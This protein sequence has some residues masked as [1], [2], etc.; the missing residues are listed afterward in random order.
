M[1][2]KNTTGVMSYLDKTAWY[3]LVQGVAKIQHRYTLVRIIIIRS[4]NHY[5][6]INR[7]KNNWCLWHSHPHPIRRQ[8]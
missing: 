1:E 7:L 5:C 8:N 2:M 3:I 4:T 6:I